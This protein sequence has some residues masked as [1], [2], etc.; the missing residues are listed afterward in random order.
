M[1]WRKSCRK[2]LDVGFSKFA[3]L[4]QDFANKYLEEIKHQMGGE[5]Q[6]Q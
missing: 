3:T 5:S 4:L 6:A 1:D 2:R